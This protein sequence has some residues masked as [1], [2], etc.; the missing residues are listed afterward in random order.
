MLAGLEEFEAL[1]PIFANTV[2]GL[3]ALVVILLGFVGNILVGL[4]VWRSRTLPKWAGALWAGAHVLDV[5]ESDVRT[6][7]R[8]L[9]HTAY[10]AVGGAGGNDKWGVDGLERASRILRPS[11][12][13]SV[14]AE[15][16]ITPF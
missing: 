12:E 8:P 5:L 15:G 6:D 4:A 7:N 10:G 2:Q 9:E 16:A 11:G 1:P 13:S 3:T 14:P